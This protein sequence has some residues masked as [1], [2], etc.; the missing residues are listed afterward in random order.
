MVEYSINVQGYFM[1]DGMSCIPSS[2]GIY[3]VYR[4]FHDM[5]NNR[6]ILKELLYIGETSNLND[7]LNNKLNL[8]QYTKFLHDDERLFFCYASVEDNAQTRKNIANRLVCVTLPSLNVED[9][10]A[11]TNDNI[12]IRIEGDRHAFLPSKVNV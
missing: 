2:S 8:N 11:N 1:E 5:E 12:I 10:N 4:G 6:A 3:L 7:S 9:A